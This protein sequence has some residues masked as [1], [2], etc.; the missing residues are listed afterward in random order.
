MNNDIEKIIKIGIGVIAI[1]VVVSLAK[2]TPKNETI[3]LDDYT[4]DITTE[5]T[6]TQNST[7][8]H[9]TDTQ[10]NT[11]DY[12]TE[13]VQENN[14]IVPEGREDEFF[15]DEIT[16]PRNITVGEDGT[17][18][19]IEPA[20]LDS[21]LA[22]VD[23]KEERKRK[24]NE[25]ML[26]TGVELVDLYENEDRSWSLIY[27]EESLRKNY[28]YLEKMFN[29]EFQEAYN[30]VSLTLDFKEVILYLRDDATLFGFGMDILR[31][32][33]CVLA[34]QI[35]S[36]VPYDEWTIHFEVVYEETGEL[37]YEFDFS[38]EDYEYNITE[39]EWN[40]KLEEM[41]ENAS[42]TDETY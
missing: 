16:I 2:L 36:G 20:R 3:T 17:V 31:L 7:T 34:G 28:T 25:S 32:K 9:T 8:E 26:K 18:T 19:V 13:D 12:T 37:M 22:D 4:P 14:L 39:E 21:D 41:K 27:D 5:N 38:E 30:K 42:A 15:A 11:V 6:T 33:W 40:Q 29:Y 1:L 23:D 24:K 10:E 35:Y